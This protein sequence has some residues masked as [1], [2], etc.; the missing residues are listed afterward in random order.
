VQQIVLLFDHLVNERQHGLR[1]AQPERL[2]GL[3]VDHELELGRLLNWQI[4][5]VSA[6]QDAI[7]VP[8]CLA[9]LFRQIGTIGNEAARFRKDGTGI[10]RRDAGAGRQR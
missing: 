4:A 6:L 8:C 5:G 7:D 9:E 2:R 3:D 10:D 1:D